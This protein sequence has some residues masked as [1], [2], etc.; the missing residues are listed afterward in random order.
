M[1]RRNHEGTCTV[2][3]MYCGK[4]YCEHKTKNT[5]IFFVHKINTHMYVYRAVVLNNLWP[6]K[7]MIGQ[8]SMEF[9]TLTIVQD[10]STTDCSTVLIEIVSY[11]C[12]STCLSCLSLPLQLTGR[13]CG[14]TSP[15]HSDQQLETISS[16][17]TKRKD[18]HHHNIPEIVNSVIAVG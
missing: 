11:Y 9:C 3:K 15:L 12:N 2:V 5:P 8:S 13:R 7:V 10:C 17:H 18:I 14:S 4:V 6:S 1:H 16:T